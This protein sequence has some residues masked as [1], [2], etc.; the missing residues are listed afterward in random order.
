MRYRSYYKQALYVS[1]HIGFFLISKVK[2]FI[3]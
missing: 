2:I 1:K 3:I